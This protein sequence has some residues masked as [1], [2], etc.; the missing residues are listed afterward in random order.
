[1]TFNASHSHTCIVFILL[2]DAYRTLN[3]FLNFECNLNLE[4][5]FSLN[6]GYNLNFTLNVLSHILTYSVLTMI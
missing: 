6:T 4:Y 1:M 2:D 3:W 5:N